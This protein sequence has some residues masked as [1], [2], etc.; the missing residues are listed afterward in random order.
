MRFSTSLVTTLLTVF[1]LASCSGADVAEEG[2][3]T[4]ER[5][6]TAATQAPPR[7]EDEAKADAIKKKAAANKGRPTYEV[8]NVRPGTITS[9]DLSAGNAD[10]FLTDFGGRPYG[11]MKSDPVLQEI[12][13]EIRAANPEYEMMLV[14]VYSD[15]EKREDRFMSNWYAFESPAVEREFL[16]DFEAYAD[17]M[18]AEF[19]AKAGAKK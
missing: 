6:E 7:D 2:E 4:E 9:T 14:S 17:D 16:N 8:A 11:V 3:A 19:E 18:I 1:L 5:A 10:V 12:A 15:T 13:N